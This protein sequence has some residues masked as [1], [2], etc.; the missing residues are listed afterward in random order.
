[1]S[2]TALEAAL[3]EAT[4]EFVS[5]IL[6]ILRSASLGDVASVGR[7]GEDA[8]GPA[9]HFS[10]PRGPGRGKPTRERA[11]RAPRATSASTAEL[12]DRTL[13]ALRRAGGPMGARAIAD[14]VGAAVEDLVK[15]L[16]ALRDDGR[17]VK[18]GDKR[19]TKYALSE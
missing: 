2:R 8:P 13:D 11:P 12:A 19:A 16:K 4:R 15:P 17:I 5:K 18:Q 6:M 1:M 7:G 10:A 14:A 3:E 9:P